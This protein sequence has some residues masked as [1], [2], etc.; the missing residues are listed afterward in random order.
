MSFFRFGQTTT[1]MPDKLS[2]TDYYQIVTSVFMV[3]LGAIILFRSLSENIAFMPLLVG[4]GFLALGV[5]RLN[6]VI[7]YF[8]EK[9]KC[10]HR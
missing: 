6:F 5:Y 4:A 3:I 1:S 10:S 8:K 2:K 9:R 7:K